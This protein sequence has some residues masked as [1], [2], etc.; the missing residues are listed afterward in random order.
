MILRN[1]PN[2]IPDFQD[3][4]RV[5]TICRFIQ[6]HQF[7][8]MHD[9]LRY[10]QALLIPT[11][12]VLHE[13]LAK[14]S[15]PAT[16]HGRF[17]GGLHLPVIHQ[18]QMSAIREVF[19]HVMIRVQWRFLWQKTDVLLGLHGLL[20]GIDTININRSFRLVQ[21]PADNIHRGRL[22]RPVRA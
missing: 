12:K 17:H 15:D 10:S 9:G 8:V 5:Q 20:T 3:L 13:P 6:H 2:Q 4:V 11:R 22:P 21:Y 7:R 19:T 18:P 14:M 16:F 1:L